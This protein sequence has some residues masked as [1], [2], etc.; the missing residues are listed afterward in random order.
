MNK[1]YYPQVSFIILAEMTQKNTFILNLKFQNLL[2][3]LN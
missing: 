2:V 3:N 1:P